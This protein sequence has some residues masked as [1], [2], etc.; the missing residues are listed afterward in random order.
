MVGASA[1]VSI[2][3]EVLQPFLRADFPVPVGR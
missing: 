1:D 3:Y 2:P